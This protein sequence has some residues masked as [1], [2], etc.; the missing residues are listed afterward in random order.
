MS[1]GQRIARTI[2]P[3]GPGL[4][5]LL[6]VS[7]SIAYSPFHHWNTWAVYPIWIGG[8]AAAIWHLVL[9]VRDDVRHIAYLLYALVNMT[10]YVVLGLLGLMF[11]TGEFL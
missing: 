9:I 3:L 1:A 6:M 11:V 2:Y 8:L 4:L 5:T 10:L 7:G